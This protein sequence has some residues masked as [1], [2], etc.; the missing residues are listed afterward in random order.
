MGSPGFELESPVRGTSARGQEVT[1]APQPGQE[2]PVE[3][4]SGGVLAEMRPDLSIGAALG[5]PGVNVRVAAARE[6]GAHAPP[7]RQ[8]R[9]GS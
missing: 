5:P 2:I 7:G 8:C 3:Q 1:R 6:L 9:D 4:V